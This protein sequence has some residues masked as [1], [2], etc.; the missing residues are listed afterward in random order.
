MFLELGFYRAVKTGLK[1]IAEIAASWLKKR[2]VLLQSAIVT[3]RLEL[4][5]I[6]HGNSCVQDRGK[7]FLRELGMSPVTSLHVFSCVSRFRMFSV[8]WKH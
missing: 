5:L 4:K 8:L 1:H 6:R 2:V 7:I 3:K